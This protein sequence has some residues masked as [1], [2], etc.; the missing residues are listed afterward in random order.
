MTELARAALDPVEALQ[1]NSQSPPPAPF[2]EELSTAQIV[3]ELAYTLKKIEKD[4]SNFSAWHQRQLLYLRLWD[5]QHQKGIETKQ[6][7]LTREFN[8]VQQAMYTDPSDQSIWQY[9]SWLIAQNPAADVL[10]REMVAILEL[11]EI[12]ADSK[13]ESRQTNRT[14]DQI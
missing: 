1:L 3:E 13:C 8:L 11:Q 4:F 5:Q 7:D 9:H 10:T 2:P 6:K 12:E 14:Q